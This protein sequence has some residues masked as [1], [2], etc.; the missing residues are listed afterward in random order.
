MESRFVVHTINGWP[1]HD[2]IGRRIWMGQ[3]RSGKL[4]NILARVLLCPGHVS[5]HVGLKFDTRSDITTHHFG[6]TVCWAFLENRSTGH[7]IT[8]TTRRIL[9][10]YLAHRVHAT[11]CPG[12][13]KMT[14]SADGYAKN[15][16]CSS[17]IG[18]RKTNKDKAHSPCLEIRLAAM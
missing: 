2:S 17:G 14:F 16:R 6:S 15:S 4:G 7:S 8:I 18:K 1:F 12:L 13:C 9:F 3:A 11:Q 5:R 10:L